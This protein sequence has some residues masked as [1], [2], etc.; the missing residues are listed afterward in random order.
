M[1]CS[2]T[3]LA[4]GC[5][6]AALNA[7]PSCIWITAEAGF[8]EVLRAGGLGDVLISRSGPTAMSTLRY[9]VMARRAV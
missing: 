1:L 5:F 3:H 6:A 9:R 8:R 7:A 2:Q 4:F